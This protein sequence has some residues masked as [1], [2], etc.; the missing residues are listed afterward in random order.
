MLVSAA[1][2]CTA[3]GT[4][5][6]GGGGG[7][8]AKALEAARARP[9]PCRRSGC[10]FAPTAAPM[11]RRLKVATGGAVSGPSDPVT[12]FCVQHGVVSLWSPPQPLAEPGRAL[13]GVCCFCSLGKCIPHSFCVHALLLAVQLTQRSY[14]C[15]LTVHGEAPS[16]LAHPRPQT[17][18]LL[19]SSRSERSDSCRPWVYA[20]AE[21]LG[22]LVG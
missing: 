12:S 4:L 14:V 7:T 15:F 17:P 6:A 19:T 2:D 3:A 8:T 21:A 10:T 16:R 9:H 18:L 22:P 5:Y 11:A 13:L 20:L 1:A